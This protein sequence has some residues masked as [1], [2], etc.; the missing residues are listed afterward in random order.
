MSAKDGAGLGATIRAWRER[1]SPAEVGLPSGRARRAAG[2]RREELAERAGVSVDYVVRLEQGRAT[3]PSAQVV[4][5]LARALRLSG[6]ERDHL[7][8]L[9]GL[10]PPNTAPIPDG[11]PAGVRR[12]LARLGDVAVAVFAADWQLA[13]WNAGWAGLLGDPSGTPPELRNFARERFPA[14]SGEAR[15]AAWPVI[16]RNAAATD[17]AIVSDLRRATGRFPDDARLARLIRDLTAGNTAFAR[18]W[19][20]G[21][22]AAHREDRKTVEHPRAGRVEVDCDVLT[23]GDS[24]L[25]IVILSARPGSA[26]EAAL[27]LVMAGAGAGDPAPAL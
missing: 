5:S 22:V 10:L 3:A 17:L 19:A 24:D 14:G 4:G 27:R 9:A 15:I 2:L 1:L 21:T 25:K 7:Y 8:R 23:D 26:D 18:L 20:S 6:A 11:L 16:A 13:W 12:V